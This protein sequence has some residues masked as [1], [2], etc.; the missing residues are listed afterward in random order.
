[1]VDS[2]P[3]ASAEDKKAELEAKL[4]DEICKRLGLKPEWIEEQKRLVGKISVISVAGELYIYR[5]VKRVEMK[6]IRRTV[7]D[8]KGD[9][10]V[11]EEKLSARGLVYPKLTEDEL[12]QG[13]AGLPSCIS[14][15]ILSFS[16]FEPDSAPI[17]L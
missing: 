6:E 1:M 5:A 12:R 4:K 16:G 13:D 9:E 11:F 3:A 8:M 15:A 10:A 2:A 7:A 17:K 14:D